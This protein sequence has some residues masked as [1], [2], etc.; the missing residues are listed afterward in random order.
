MF[1][2][3]RLMEGRAG[4]RGLYVGVRAAVVTSV[5]VTVPLVLVTG[6]EPL[7]HSVIY[8]VDRGTEIESIYSG[9]MLLGGRLFGL[10]TASYANP[11]DLSQDILSP[12]NSFVDAI[13][14]PLGGLL[15]GVI[16]WR[17]YRALKTHS[18]ARE[19]ALLRT[20]LLVMLAFM[21]AFRALPGHYLLAVLPLA[22]LVRFQGRRQRVFVLALLG[23]L[24][25]GQLETVVWPQLVAGEWL[26]ILVLNLRNGAILASFVLLLGGEMRPFIAGAKSASQRVTRTLPKPS[27]GWAVESGRRSWQELPASFESYRE[28]ATAVSV[29]T[30]PLTEQRT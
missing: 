29:Q 1:L 6:I 5:V 11:A 13:A 9:L 23:A 19:G 22:A 18:E 30:T 26:G 10:A 28:K 21:I 14:V 24:L 3:Y 15:I 12:L 4:Y 8:H 7:I 20:T 25:L 2:L 16:Y 17:F 27:L